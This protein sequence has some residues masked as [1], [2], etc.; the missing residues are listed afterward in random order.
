MPE[1]TSFSNH[2]TLELSVVTLP[3]RLRQTE[4][5]HLKKKWGKKIHRSYRRY[6]FCSNCCCRYCC[7]YCCFY[8][9]FC[10][11]ILH[12]CSIVVISILVTAAANMIIVVGVVF[13][14]T[15]EIAVAAAFALNYPFYPS[16][17]SGTSKQMSQ[18]SFLFFVEGYRKIKISKLFKSNV[19]YGEEKGTT[20][21][22][23]RIS[24][25][26]LLF[27][28]SW[29]FFGKTKPMCYFRSAAR[30]V[31]FWSGYF[32][33]A[34]VFQSRTEGDLPEVCLL[35]TLYSY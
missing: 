5:E 1:T 30:S 32:L 31:I 13:A 35:F 28:F 6:H 29:C 24:A 3:Q 14:A 16:V 19:W 22:L 34:F 10:C 33:T 4:I 11:F 12:Y 23:S 15:V 27:L 20:Q 2:G 21:K 25:L 8:C 18:H 9:H 26:S 7:Y 17:K